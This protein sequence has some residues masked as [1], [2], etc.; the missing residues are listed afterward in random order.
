M[1][2]LGMVGLFGR[3]LMGWLL[4]LML[5]VTVFTGCSVV[6]PVAGRTSDTIPPRTALVH[7]STGPETCYQ[8]AYTELAEMPA[9]MLASDAQV[10]HLSGVVN[11]VVLF[12]VQITGEPHGCAVAVHASL[13]PGKWVQGEFTEVDDYVKRLQR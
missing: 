5:A 13:L 6:P 3:G 8:R 10:R 4:F 9:Q 7:L 2:N 1:R 12:N 11:G